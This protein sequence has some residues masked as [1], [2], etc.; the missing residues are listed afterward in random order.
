[1]LLNVCFSQCRT[2]GGGEIG[3][4]GR[5]LTAIRSR[6]NTKSERLSSGNSVQQPV[7]RSNNHFS[8][9]GHLTARMA[10]GIRYAL[11]RQYERMSASSKSVL[12][13]Y[14]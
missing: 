11:F 14:H 12:F 10:G 7:Q 9:I 3:E 1:M 13:P 6:S 2:L 8:A 4:S 5:L